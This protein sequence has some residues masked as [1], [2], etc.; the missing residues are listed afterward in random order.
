MAMSAR[1]S[2]GS[3]NVSIDV[4][5]AVAILSVIAL[6]WVNSR[7]SVPGPG[8]WNAIEQAFVRIG[9]HGTYG[10]TLFFI[11]S[12]F[13]ITRTTMLREVNLFALS[14]RDFYVR[15]IA[16][17]QPLFILAVFYGLV[18]MRYGGD[19]ASRIFQY[20]FYDPKAVYGG[21]F[22]VAL[23]TFTYNWE[24]MIHGADFFFRGMHWDVMW[25]LAV[26]EQFYLLFPLA[27]LWAGNLKR[28]Y[29][30][31]WG[32]VALGIVV[33]VAC[34]AA[35]A[36]FLVK[37]SNSFVCF[38]TLA[39]GVICALAGDRLPHGRNLCRA[40]LALGALL[41]AYAY[42]HGGVVALIAGA[43]LMIHG[44]RYVDVFRPWGAPLARIGQ[45]SY[46]LYL[47]HATGLY[48]ASP[49]SGRFG[50][51]GGFV[52]VAG[53]T[54]ILGE[55]VFRG[56]EAPMNRWIRARFLKPRPVAQPLPADGSA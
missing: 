21:E 28:L 34:D 2:E 22:I 6:H 48:L 19:P 45:L 18:M 27:I 33:R 20:T 31:L 23:F 30:V 37:V 16:R 52:L 56:F 4:L 11:L 51:I 38:D 10:V 42:Y 44:A 13:L 24:R 54:W 7:L 17:I 26:E 3:R 15:R 9:D 32:V 41:I 53:I 8:G 50:I 12:G 25:T 49:Y 55:I 29:R 43:L 1:A 35:H 36:G 40:L 46:G 5:R 39:L 14:A 47:L